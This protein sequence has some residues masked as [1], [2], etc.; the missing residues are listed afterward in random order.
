MVVR[1]VEEVRGFTETSSRL[2]A[3]RPEF[4]KRIS[5]FSGST[6]ALI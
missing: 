1:P 4:R 6:Y 5:A 2:L 3:I